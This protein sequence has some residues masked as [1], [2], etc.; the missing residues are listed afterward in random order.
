MSRNGN[1]RFSRDSRAPY[2]GAGNG[3]DSGMNEHDTKGLNHD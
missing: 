3:K 2:K 1:T